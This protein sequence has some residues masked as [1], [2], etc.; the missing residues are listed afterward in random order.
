[1]KFSKALSG[2]CSP[3]SISMILMV[4]GVLVTTIT[5][6]AEEYSRGMPGAVSASRSDATVGVRDPVKRNY[7]SAGRNF[8]A[9]NERAASKV[10]NKPKTKRI[11]FG[12]CLFVLLVFVFINIIAVSA[13]A[14]IC[15]N[16]DYTGSMNAVTL[17]RKPSVNS[18]LIF[19]VK[20]FPVLLYYYGERGRF[21][22]PLCRRTS[23][24]FSIRSK[25]RDMQ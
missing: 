7:T 14:R 11:I 12:V 2:I 16:C 23:T 13:N 19:L 3:H 6:H 24:N 4:T 8:A 1:M 21:M 18:L 20:F 22:C 9:Q 5:T 10:N 15:R 25:R 17:S